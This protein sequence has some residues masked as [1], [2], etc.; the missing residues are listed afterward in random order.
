MIFNINILTYIF[1]KCYKK[2]YFL[3]FGMGL[4][5]CRGDGLF[6]CI[7]CTGKEKAAMKRTKTEIE[8]KITKFTKYEHNLFILF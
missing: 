4:G 6:L 2:L 5:I 7:L 8:N 1:Y 3:G